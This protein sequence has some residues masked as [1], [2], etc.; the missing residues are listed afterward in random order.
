MPVNIQE[1]VYRV[2][3]ALSTQEIRAYCNSVPLQPGMLL[4]ADVVLEQRSLL[5]WLFEPILSL[6]GHV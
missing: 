5:H 6:K 3:V 4:S 1:P 2:E